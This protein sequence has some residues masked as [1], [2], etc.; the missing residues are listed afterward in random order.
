MGNGTE[1]G[2]VRALGS[3]HS[4]AHHWLL[5]RYTAI[6]NMLGGL[7]LLFALVA[8]GDYSFAS[9]HDWLHAPLP[10]LMAGLFVL[11]TFWH[12]RLGLQVLTEDYVHEHANKFAATAALNLLSFAGAAFGLLC[13]ARIALGA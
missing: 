8:K 7:F 4:G 1:L 13:V 9:I 3:S 11:S 6:G 12:A 2:R 5:Q 10:A